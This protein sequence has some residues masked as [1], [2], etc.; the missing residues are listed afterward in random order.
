MCPHCEAEVEEAPTQEDVAAVEG[1]LAGM[2][3]EILDELRNAFKQST[4]GEDFVNRIMVG[5]CPSCSS[6]NTGDCDGDP[7]ID[8]ITVGRCFDCGQLWCCD[9]GE[10]FK[11]AQ[12]TAHECPAWEGI[13]LD[14]DFDDDWG[15]DE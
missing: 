1:L 10:L 13:D 14:E 6:S 11:D 15:E 5:D 4:S 7:E 8:D 9:C 12:S 3:P 2:N